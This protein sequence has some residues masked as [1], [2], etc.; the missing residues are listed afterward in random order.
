MLPE[1]SINYWAV[2]VSVVASMFIGSVW[3]AMPVFGRM[4]MGLIGKTEEELK[5]G[6]GPAMSGAIV[7]AFILVYVF[8]HII[9]YVNATTLSE[10]LVTGFWLWL[11]FPFSVIA[12]QNIFAQRPF[13]LT[14]INSGYYLVQFLVIGAV[15]AVW[16]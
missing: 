1:A 13:K 15:L 8:A 3:Y 7:L 14:L 10:G 5:K 11:G 4:W 12:V 9:D 6:Q 16:V 2:L